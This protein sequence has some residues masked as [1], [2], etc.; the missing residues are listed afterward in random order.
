MKIRCREGG[1][2][3][4]LADGPATDAVGLAWLGQ[5]GFAVKYAQCFLLIDP[6]LSDSLA[7]KYRGTLFPHQRMAAAPIAPDELR[8]VAFVLC[9]HRH[10]DHMDPGT[11]PIIAEN[12]PECRF[13]VPRAERRSAVEIGV[14]AS[15]IIAVNAGES[16]LLAPDLVV[17]AIPAAHETL[18]VNEHGEHHYLGYLLRFGKLT[19]YHSGDCVP[20]DGLAERLR[21]AKVDLALLPVNG[22]DEYRREHGVPGNMTFDEAESLCRAAGI[23][24][25]IPHHFGMFDFNTVDPSEWEQKISKPH[26]G[27]SASIVL[28]TVVLPTMNAWVEVSPPREK[29]FSR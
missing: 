22:R 5:A 14:P 7:K 13:V 1:V 20:Y 16:E 4:M 24:S 21:E 17:T 27:A 6:Y 9:T 19:L 11:L 26:A 29:A 15:K 10:S 28:P 2:R 3:T 12:N 23:A 25:W 8:H 18:K